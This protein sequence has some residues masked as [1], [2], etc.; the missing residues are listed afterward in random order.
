MAE[1]ENNMKKK[2]VKII[3]F[4]NIVAILIIISL[5]IFKYI[6]LKNN[7]NTSN[8]EDNVF[9]FKNFD[10]KIN[11]EYGFN[12]VDS[13]KFSL[14]SYDDKNWYAYVEIYVDKNNVTYNQMDKFYRRLIDFGLNVDKPEIVKINGDDIIVYKILE[15]D[16]Y[17]IYYNNGTKYSFEITLTIEDDN[18]ILN[19]IL[20]EIITLLNNSEINSLRGNYIYQE[21]ID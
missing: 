1:V 15:S 2:Y 9:S 10:F 17:L 20:E 12:E 21:I 11:D 19:T 8:L 7:L 18:V 14:H 4:V 16:N 5:L 3:I 13:D 6:N